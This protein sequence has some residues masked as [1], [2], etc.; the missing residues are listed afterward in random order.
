MQTRIIRF[1]AVIFIACL[2]VAGIYAAWL[3]GTGASSRSAWYAVYLDTGDLYF[4]HLSSFPS[5]ALTDAWYVQHTPQGDLSVSD[6][7]KV[8]WKPVGVIQINRQH[9]VWTARIAS[10]SPLLSAMT[11]QPSSNDHSYTGPGMNEIPLMPG[12]G[13]DATSSASSVPNLIH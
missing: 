8:S 13:G 10:D 11:P 2:V 7:S 12:A 4:G 6:F 5:F 9:V 3:Y 1:C